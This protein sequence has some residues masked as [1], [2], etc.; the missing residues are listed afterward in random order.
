M[1]SRSSAAGAAST[2]P[3]A[4][5]AARTSAPHTAP[6]DELFAAGPWETIAVGDGGNEIGMGALPRALI[7][8]HVEHGATIACVTPR[9]HLI[10][11]GVSHWGAY[12][13]L[14]ALAVVRPDWRQPLLR[15]LDEALDRAH[16]RSDL[17]RRAGGRRRVAAPGADDRQSRP[18]RPSPEIADGPRPRREVLHEALSEFVFESYRYDRAD[19]RAGAAL[20]V[21]G[22]PAVRGKA[23][24][25]FSAAARCHS[26]PR[27]CSTGSSGW[28]FCCRGSAI[29]RRLCPKPCVARR[30]RSTATP[31]LFLQEFLRKRPR[32]IRLEKPDFVARPLPIS[33]GPSRPAER[34]SAVDLPR[35]TCVPV[36]GGKDSIVTV[37]CLKAAGEDLVLFSLGDAAPIAACIAAAELPSIRVRRRLDPGLFELNDKAR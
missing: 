11:A 10:V 35:R 26:P 25:R 16:S 2:A 30:S 32:R 34:R 7:A 5:C 1:R 22:R 27:R 24:F 3:R 21:S 19:G 28:F 29:T 12:A 36:G 23:A 6:L 4:T 31:P 13:L 18:C 33:V 14:G 9:S 15:C 17:A 20:S 8:A 37:E